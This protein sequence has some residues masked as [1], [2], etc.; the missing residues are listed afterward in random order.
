MNNKKGKWGEVKKGSQKL[1]YFHQY[2]PNKNAYFRIKDG[3]IL[4]TAPKK[5]S[6][7]YLEK[8][9]LNKFDFF[10]QKLAK[11]KSET[12]LNKLKLFGNIYNVKYISSESF[13]YQILDSTIFIFKSSNWDKEKSLLKVLETEMIKKTFQIEKDI[14]KNLIANGYK[15]VP[16]VFKNVKSYYGKCF[17]KE[18]RIHLNINLAKLDPIFIRYI[19]YHEYTH[20]KVQGHGKNFYKELE[21]LM[22]EAKNLD[23]RLNKITKGIH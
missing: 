4:V 14:E 22:P 13:S 10:Y 17:T 21:K 15:L 11:N 16:Y 18:K 8:Y 7:K 2:K 9:I 20:F 1:K 23:R 12:N 19:L 6:S 5:A 3:Y